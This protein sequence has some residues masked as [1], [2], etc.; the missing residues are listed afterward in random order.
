MHTVHHTA[1]SSLTLSARHSDAHISEDKILP[2][3]S[4]NK[5]GE[6]DTDYREWADKTQS[7]TYAPPIHRFTGGT[8][9]IRGN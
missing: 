3:E 6:T 7:R 1:P 2:H 9:G 5:R 4:D 8:N